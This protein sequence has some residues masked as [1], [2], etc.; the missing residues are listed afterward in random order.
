MSIKTDVKWMKNDTLYRAGT[1]P[2]IY[3]DLPI[4]VFNMH[5]D[6]NGSLYLE[7]M[8]DEFELPTKLYGLEEKFI[9]RVE[10]AYDKLEENIGIMMSGIKGT[11]KSVTAKVICNKLKLPVIVVD[12]DYPALS[13]FLCHVKQDCIVFVDEYEKIIGGYSGKGEVDFL[14]LMDGATSGGGRKI[15][16]LTANELNISPNLIERPSRI[17][18][19]KEFGNLTIENI[20]MIVEDR[21]N[22]KELKSNVI[23]FICTLNLITVDT[24][25]SVISEVNITGE[26]P[27]EFYDVFNIKR[28]DPVYSI[29][30]V[31][32]EDNNVEMF[33]GQTSNINQKCFDDKSV[34]NSLNVDGN[35]MG[36]IEEVLS[37]DTVLLKSVKDGEEII[38]IFRVE[39]CYVPRPGMLRAIK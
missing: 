28:I 26:T 24:V 17:R 12:A 35:K 38:G 3:D 27:E 5:Q 37:E 18:Y 23:D 7:H 33:V 22:I 4:G 31:N 21:L 32:P 10:N 11:G 6:M 15:F 20:K 14:T 19:L 13:D 2:D 29:Y 16:L 30:M 9:A 39:K 36:I 25:C 34:G 8:S 1:L